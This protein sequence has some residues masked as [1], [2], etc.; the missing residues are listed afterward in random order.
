ANELLYRHDEPRIE[1][2]AHG[3]PWS[4]D[5]D[6][7]QFRLVSLGNG[8]ARRIVGERAHA[9]RDGYHQPSLTAGNVIGKGLDHTQ[10]THRI[11][12]EDMGPRFVVDI[13]GL[14]PRHTG[15]PRA[16]DEH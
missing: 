16:V 11:H 9:T 10:G 12:V 4:F 3:R 7:H 15:D 14:L 6:G 2:V 8:A 13:A 5:G 1:V